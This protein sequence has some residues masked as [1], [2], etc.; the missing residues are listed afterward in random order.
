MSNKLNVRSWTVKDGFQFPELDKKDPMYYSEMENRSSSGIAISGGGT[1][2]VSLIQGY[3]KALQEKG[4]MD[5]IAYVSGVSGGCWGSTPFAFLPGS[6]A[7]D[8][9]FYAPVND[10]GKY[11]NKEDEKSAQRT[12]PANEN[13]KGSITSAVTHAHLADL[14]LEGSEHK[15]EAYERA[16][17]EIFLQPFGI[18]SPNSDY[19]DRQYFTCD[20]STLA[21]L[22]ERNPFLKEEA[23]Q[24]KIM[25]LAKGRPYH[26][27]NTTMLVPTGN[28][29]VPYYHFPF[30]VTPSYAGM[31]PKQNVRTANGTEI[32][33][34]FVESAGFNTYAVG[35]QG[36]SV[37][38]TAEYRYELCEPVGTS[39][40]AIEEMILNEHNLA[41]Y[42]AYWLPEFKYW[43]PAQVQMGNAPVAQDLYFGD[44]GIMENTGITPLILRGVK[45]IAAFIS[46]PVL[47]TSTI[48]PSDENVKYNQYEV[49]G[50]NELACL[51]G[52]ELIKV[53]KEAV[54]GNN[55]LEVLTHHKD[56]FNR[57][58]F[59]NSKGQFKDILNAF[60]TSSS[61]DANVYK[62]TL[63]T[64][65]NEIFGIKGGQTVTI[66][67][68][69]IKQW[70]GFNEELP[71][72]L[73]KEI[74]NH[75]GDLYNFPDVAVFG[76]NGTDII[77]LTPVQANMLGSYGYKMVNDNW[78]TIYKDV[79][80][81]S[82]KMI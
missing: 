55:D 18:H 17:G 61:M 76:E 37:N 81:T 58:I 52:E 67:W 39:G 33:G 51:F 36:D 49:F 78:E 13:P 2:S 16:V 77:Q 80:T 35:T 73:Q 24:G 9:A 65:D 1:V 59:D 63:T 44:G 60:A 45:N 26:I 71:Q 40:S 50:Y 57:Q 53:E 62:Q 20:E 54:S 70:Q 41:K 29:D 11:Y 22:L 15:H 6:A 30:E 66:V 46:Q 47:L 28:A 69:T 72:S 32:G 4:A 34:G 10:P 7:A 21:D 82:E 31:F 23:A 14:T 27:M 79:L 5:Q 48:D 75:T 64:V 74:E 8:A 56:P 25:M 42:A 19:A 68:S 12:V 3:F 38:T 43:N